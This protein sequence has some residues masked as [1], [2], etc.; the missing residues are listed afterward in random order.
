[1]SR[2][3]IIASQ[4][5]SG[6]S[7]IGATCCTPAFATITSRRPKRSSASVNRPPVALARGEV[8]GVTHAWTVW[9]RIQ[10][11]GEDVEAV[12]LEAL[13]DRSPDPACRA[14]YDGGPPVAC[15]FHRRGL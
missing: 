13:G 4:R 7:E 15:A 2:R 5:S 1:M 3:A 9:R 6:N 8:G 12:I 10:V 14:G 11:H